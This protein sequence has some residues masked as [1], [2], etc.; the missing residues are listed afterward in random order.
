M[1]ALFILEMIFKPIFTLIIL[2]YGYKYYKQKEKIALKQR[3]A[4]I[5]I[6]EISCVVLFMITGMVQDFL[7]VLIHFEWYTN[8]LLVETIVTNL[9]LTFIDLLFLSWTWRFFI[10]IY[11]MKIIN[12]DCNQQWINIINPNEM[13]TAQ[14]NRNWYYRHKSKFGNAKWFGRHCILPITIIIVI[15]NTCVISIFHPYSDRFED[16]LLVLYVAINYGFMLMMIIF[17]SILFCT[18]PKFQDHFFVYGEMKRL[19]IIALFGVFISMFWSYSYVGINNI[20]LSATYI[21]SDAGRIVQDIMFLA[22]TMISTWWVL[23]KLKMVSIRTHE[24]AKSIDHRS[25]IL[26]QSAKSHPES[27]Q[28]AR[29]NVILRNKDYFQVFMLHL[30]KEFSY[31]FLVAFIEIIQLQNYIQDN[32]RLNDDEL[33]F[34]DIEFYESI[35]K[36]IIVYGEDE[37]EEKSDS[38]DMLQR[39]KQKSTKLYDKYIDSGM[40]YEIIL[41]K[42]TKH[43]IS[44][45]MSHIDWIDDDE[46]DIDKVMKLWDDVSNELHLLLLNSFNRFQSTIQCRNL[47]LPLAY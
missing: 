26:L 41:T 21:I 14:L 37:K 42:G 24:K 27:F 8:N 43:E 47:K 3:Y 46:I 19:I 12:I 4:Y 15:F 36:S 20:S 22:E 38:D 7:W 28:Q 16:D 11:D 13:E 10:I 35:P 9:L 30:G 45:V 29:L 40:G 2:V 17:L 33:S 44:D 25:A 18:I 1:W 34:R 23:A 32:M 6:I 31:Q 39:I 5:N